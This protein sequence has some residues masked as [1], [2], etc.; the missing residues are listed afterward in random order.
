MTV[1]ISMLVEIHRPFYGSGYH[2]SRRI[3]E[4]AVIYR[5]KKIFSKPYRKTTQ[6]CP[7]GVALQRIR[8]VT[9]AKIRRATWS[10]SVFAAEARMGNP[11]QRLPLSSTTKRQLPGAIKAFLAALVDLHWLLNRVRLYHPLIFSLLMNPLV[12]LIFCCR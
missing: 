10:P 6:H 8:N 9:A 5:V 7:F 12:D 2:P 4:Y 3:G 1:R 11:Q